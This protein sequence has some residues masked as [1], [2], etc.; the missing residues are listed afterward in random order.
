V[1]RARTPLRDVGWVAAGG[2]V[3]ALARVGLA[4]WFPPATGRF[5]LTTFLENV[6]G[7]FLLGAI[8]TLLAERASSRPSVRLF[9]CTGALG[10]FTTYSTFA[11]ELAQLLDGRHVAVAA[12]YA[13]ASLV[14]GLG[15]GLVGIRAGRTWPR[16]RRR[17]APE[18]GP[19]VAP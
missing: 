9:V 19:G 7:A 18:T 5:P 6:V 13:A 1:T 4:T 11:T 10:A 17:P 16:R 12:G 15:A 2:A 14:A 8:L 3:G